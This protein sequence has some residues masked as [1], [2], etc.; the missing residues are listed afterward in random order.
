MTWHE[1]L[2]LPTI[3][4]MIKYTSEQLAFLRDHVKGTSAKDLAVLFN[5]EF[6]LSVSTDTMHS[7]M[8]NHKLR[9]G[10]PCG[11][12]SKYLPIHIEFLK[13]NVQGKSE[14]ELTEAFNAEFG[15]NVSVSAICNL[16][17]IYSLKSGTVGGR[18]EKGQIAYN[19]GK[20][21]DD[22]MSPEGQ[23]AAR[24]TTF[25]TGRLPQTYKSVG[26]ERVDVD[27]YHWVKVKD[28]KTWRMKH[29]LLWESVKGTVPKGCVILFLDGNPGNIIIDNLICVSRAELVRLN[30]NRL[31]SDNAD[32]TR[33]GVIVAKILT[34][35]GRIKQRKMH[36]K[37]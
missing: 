11:G 24:K 13:Q 28:P 8:Q 1:C 3:Q 6:G 33:S 37:N 21:W 4:K 16:K 30:Q 20:K 19:A 17:N 14:K 5:L 29:V 23:T 9:N 7:I 22:F 35:L 12:K 32:A 15:L 27:G 34:Q 25:K 18:F 36:Q 2:V 31:I 26:S 10:I